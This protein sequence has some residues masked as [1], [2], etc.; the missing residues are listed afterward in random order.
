MNE[1]ADLRQRCPALASPG[2]DAIR[3]L[4][5]NPLMALENMALQATYLTQAVLAFEGI[6]EPAN[7]AQMA[8]LNLL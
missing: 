2:C 6:D 7:V 3:E 8:R 5:E 4:I 1:F